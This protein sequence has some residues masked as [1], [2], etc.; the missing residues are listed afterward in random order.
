MFCRCLF[1]N[2]ALRNMWIN[3]YCHENVKYR[4]LCH[5]VRTL[6]HC[7][8][9]WM[10]SIQNIWMNFAWKVTW[11]HMQTVAPIRKACET[12]SM[13]KLLTADSQQSRRASS[14][15]GRGSS[16]GVR[17]SSGTKWSA[18]PWWLTRPR[19]CL[20]EEWWLWERSLC[21][22]QQNISL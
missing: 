5:A 11:P 20:D 13:V 6:I 19:S 10:D 1:Y 16:T 3:S 15:R 18:F 7:C 4:H 12:I 21:W 22:Q 14:A 17:G 9:M 8:H 2:A